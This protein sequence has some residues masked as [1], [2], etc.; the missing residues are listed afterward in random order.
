MKALCWDVG[1]SAAVALLDER[2]I[3]EVRRYALPG[4]SVGEGFRWLHFE[5]Y[6]EGLFLEFK[7]DAL[8]FEIPFGKYARTL[9]VQFG[10]VAIL[11]KAAARARIDYA[12]IKPSDAKRFATGSG[13]ASKEKM[14]E[15]LRERHYEIKPPR[16]AEQMTEDEIDATWVAAYAREALL[17][18]EDDPIEDLF[19]GES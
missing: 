1:T 15:A 13:N 9:K 4:P 11:E 6:V 19:G 12:G 10:M 5:H 18:Y 16:P 3:V 17:V 7:P 14:A 2:T 8:V